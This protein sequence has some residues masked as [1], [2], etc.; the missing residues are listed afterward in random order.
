MFQSL[1]YYMYLNSLFSS[2]G[3]EITF[4]MAVNRDFT[5]S[6]TFTVTRGDPG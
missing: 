4:A 3:E 1:S 5:S 6:F 2:E